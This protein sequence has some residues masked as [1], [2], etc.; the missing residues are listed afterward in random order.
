MTAI[1]ALLLFSV[2]SGLPAGARV[3]AGP[4]ALFP[5]TAF[6]TPDKDQD[7]EGDMVLNRYFQV[8]KKNILRGVIM[9][10][11]FAGRLPKMEKSATLDAKR[12]V[13][14]EGVIEYDTTDRQG[15]VTIQKYLIATFI[16]GEMENSGKDTSK[17]AVTRDNYKFKYKGK[18][19]KDGRPVFVFEINPRKNREGLFKGEIWLDSDTGLT[20]REAGRFVKSPSVFL[21]KVYFA[22]EYTIRDGF[23]VPK[24]IQTAI[25]TRFWGL[26]ELDVQYSAFTWEDHQA[27]LN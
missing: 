14:K 21:K 9:V 16:N 3:E 8:S 23:A 12:H 24:L 25:E 17:I 18:R 26:A 10:A 15:D 27:E 4:A 22:R 11:H 6:V 2:F 20:V 7:G 19:E 1:C 13:N 5:D